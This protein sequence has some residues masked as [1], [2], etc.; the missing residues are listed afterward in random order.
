MGRLHP[1][2]ISRLSE[3]ILLALLAACSHAPPAIDSPQAV[4]YYR[5]ELAKEP[6]GEE[7][8]E[9][10]ASLEEAELA[11]AKKQGTILALRTFLDE[12]PDGAHQRE[13]RT[14]LEA[15]RWNEAGADGSAQ[16]L[17][18]FLDAEPRG[19]HAGEAWSRL[20]ALELD[21]AIARHEG[22][23]L[24]AWLQAN[25]NAADEAKARARTALAEAELRSAQ[26]AP[27]WSR[28]AKLRRWLDEFPESKERAQAAEL[29]AR[30]AVA[31]AALLGDRDELRAWARAGRAEAGEALARL[32]F[33][34]AAARLDAQALEEIARA[35]GPLMEGPWQKQARELLAALGRDRAKPSAVAA[36]RA[37]YL[38]APAARE[39][40]ESSRGRARELLQAA[41]GADGSALPAIV[42]QLSQ[43]DLWVQREALAAAVELLESLP[44][45]EMRLRASRLAA[46]LEPVARDGAKL[47][48]LALLQLALGDRKAAL[49]ASRAAVAAEPRSLVAWTVEW[50]LERLA[51]DGLS[52]PLAESGWLRALEAALDARPPPSAEARAPRPA[53]GDAPLWPL[54]AIWQAALE[55]QQGLDASGTAPA[56][57]S[58]LRARA[59]AL[60]GRA[61]RAIAEAARHGEGAAACG[62]ELDLLGRR[63]DRRG[64]ERA[65]AARALQRH[66]QAVSAEALRRAGQRDPS[67]WVRRALGLHPWRA[68]LFPDTCD[69]SSS[70]PATITP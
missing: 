35:G 28:R 27:A 29:E 2:N 58:S 53:A 62:G 25:P 11:A 69:A 36:A 38:P 46:Q 59:D 49:A 6:T 60:A 67:L 32:D 5:Q 55:A 1:R 8:V 34:E 70:Q 45:D 48:A 4:P 21:G 20:L 54:C 7:A 56:D 33:E 37:L 26:E 41:L 17:R 10:R 64:Q 12:F 57:S 3:A 66:P 61:E 31:E 44:E 24:R 15:L 9:L 39:E 63:R 19:A 47:A 42:A 14:R 50:R 23:A 65:E 13:A 22:P 16:A 68:G 30:S 52:R 18:A 51:G 40:D 43:G